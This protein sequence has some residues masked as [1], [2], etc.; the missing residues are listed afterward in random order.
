[1]STHD[2]L[3]DIFTKT[4]P[5]NEFANFVASLGIDDMPPTPDPDLFSPD[6]D[7]NISNISVY[8]DAQ[9]SENEREC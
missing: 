6:P 8:T 9:D 2:N 7:P 3:A 4:L 5:L 1:M